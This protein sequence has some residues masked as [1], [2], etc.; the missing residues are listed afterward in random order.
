MVLLFRSIPRSIMTTVNILFALAAYF[1]DWS[2]T[3]LFNPRWP[4]HAKFHNGQ[5]MSFGALS[6]LMALYLLGR[7]NP[8]PEAAKDSL[9]IAAIVGSLTTT[10]GLSA[11]FYPGTHWTDPEFDNR[12]L[13]GVQAYIFAGQLLINWIAYFWEKANLE[14]R[15]KTL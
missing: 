11:I 8:T 7:R 2:H 9:F 6:A 14:K 4:P 15:E 12:A 3:H 1:A 5:S 13:I 10:A